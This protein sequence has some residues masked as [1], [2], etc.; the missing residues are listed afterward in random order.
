MRRGEVRRREWSLEGGEFVDE[1]GVVDVNVV[2]EL[3]AEQSHHGVDVVVGQPFAEGRQRRTQPG[4]AHPAAPRVVQRFERLAQVPHLRL[5]AVQLAVRVHRA[6]E[7]VQ[8]YLRSRA[9]RKS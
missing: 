3:V 4:T 7:L 6:Q 9:T 1:G 2:D 8:R 5:L